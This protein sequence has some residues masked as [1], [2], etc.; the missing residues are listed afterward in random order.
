MARAAAGGA[1]VADAGRLSGELYLE[2][3]ASDRH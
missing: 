2:A 1:G 3:L